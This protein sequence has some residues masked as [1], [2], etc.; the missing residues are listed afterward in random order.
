MIKLGQLQGFKL[1]VAKIAAV[2]EVELLVQIL[3]LVLKCIIEQVSDIDALIS[4]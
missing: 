3:I 1:S 2:T 4:S